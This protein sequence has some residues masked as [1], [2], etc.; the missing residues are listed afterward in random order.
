MSNND[1]PTVA[2]TTEEEGAE[3]LKITWNSIWVT[4]VVALAQTL[5]FYGFFMFQRK[6]T[7]QQGSFD[8][9]EPRQHTR[10]HRSPAPFAESWWKAAWAVPQ[11][12][13][14]RCVGLDT[15]M[16]LRFLRLAA[17][18]ALLGTILGAILIPVYATGDN[19]GDDTLAFN[20]LTLARVAQGSDR[21]WAAVAAWWVFTA[22]ILHEFVVEWKVRTNRT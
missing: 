21:L 5:V 16:F 2:P 9:Y 7:S 3:A 6:K 18:T 22:F 1:S 13:L 12:E 14:L 8:L 10:A 11:D 19:E 17:R 4:A 20:Q 15:Y